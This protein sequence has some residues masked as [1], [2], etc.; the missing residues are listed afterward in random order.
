MPRYLIIVQPGN[1]ARDYWLSSPSAA[2]SDAF[3]RWVHKATG[4]AVDV[5]DQKTDSNR[6]TLGNF[7]RDR[8]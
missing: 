5:H 2:D 4:A 8:T 3:A 6:L 1:G 7:D